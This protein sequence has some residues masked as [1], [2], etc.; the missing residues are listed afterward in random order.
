MVHGA[1]GRQ[2]LVVGSGHVGH[3]DAQPGSGAFD[4][5]GTGCIYPLSD[6]VVCF[7]QPIRLRG[8][9]VIRRSVFGHHLPNPFIFHQLFGI[10]GAQGRAAVKILFVCLGNIC[11][12]PAAEAVVRDLR[13]DLM[14]DSA[15]TGSWHI[16]KPPYGPMQDAMR[17]RGWDMSDLRARQVVVADFEAFDLIICMDDDNVADIERLRPG[18]C[19][20]PVRLFADYA[21]ETGAVP[22]PYFTRDFDGALDMIDRCAQGLAAAV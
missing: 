11:R 3:V 17:A 10:H 1:V 12:S 19:P 6:L 4:V 9:G 7:G 14:V 21:G 16:G 2:H 18:A 22:D 15:G 20:T 8:D 5:A 13:P